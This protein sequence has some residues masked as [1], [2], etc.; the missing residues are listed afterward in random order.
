ML[1]NRRSSPYCVT[2][3]QHNSYYRQLRSGKGVLHSLLTSNGSI[4][5]MRHV[6]GETFDMQAQEGHAEHDILTTEEAADYLRV[7]LRTIHRLLARGELRGRKVGRAWRFHRADLEAYVRSS[8]MP[9][10]HNEE[11]KT[12]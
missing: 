2:I 5:K 1:L 4:D 7:H 11:S 3:S 9:S 10:T 12:E 8:S 6:E